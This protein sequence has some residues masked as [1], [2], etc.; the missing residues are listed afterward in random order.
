MPRAFL[1]YWLPEQIQA[2]ITDGLLDHAASEQF[3]RIAS[4]DVLWIT[5]KSR[6]EPLITVGPLHVADIVSQ[7]E[8]EQRLPYQPWQATYHA[9][10]IPGT[11][12]VTCEIALTSILGDLEFV[13]QRSARLDL[14]KPIGRQLQTMRQLTEASAE[15]LATLWYGATSH[16]F[17][18]YEAIQRELDSYES[19][20]QPRIVLARREQAFL[21][22]YLFRDSEFG[23]CAI[24]G[25]ELPIS[26]LVAAHIKPRAQCSDAERR[27]YA[28]NVVPMCLLGCEVLFE[29]GWV[30]VRDGKVHV[31][32][33]SRSNDRLDRLLKGLDGRPTVAWKE[34]RVK[35]FVWHAQH[36]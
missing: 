4:G 25:E 27:D 31:R 34:G 8:A 14:A 35:Y 19:L 16:A 1:V 30:V 12:T 5:G 15:K 36:A 11:E 7:R 26:F 9:L 10:C 13:S 20:D 28:N 33:H 21:R 18:T 29:L 22:Q 2:S 3:G 32:R 6:N 17:T 24:C 23:A